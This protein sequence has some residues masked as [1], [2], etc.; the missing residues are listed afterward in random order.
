[1]KVAVLY[2]SNSED[3]RA[4]REFVEEYRRRTGRSLEMQDVNTRDG[5]S[6]ATL[7]DIVRYPAVLVMGPDGTLIQNWQGDN[8]PLMN[9]VMYYH[10]S[11]PA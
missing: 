9:E 8:L 6:T 2:Q 4:V 10:N 7:Y 5:A 1:M 3:E 11:M